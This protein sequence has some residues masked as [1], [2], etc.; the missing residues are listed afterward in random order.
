MS[1]AVVVTWKSRIPFLTKFKNMKLKIDAF[2]IC[3][4][5]FKV[6]YQRIYNNFFVDLSVDRLL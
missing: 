3:M 5:I 6:L 4:I 1:V 2:S